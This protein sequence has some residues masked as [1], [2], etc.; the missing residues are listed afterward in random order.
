CIDDMWVPKNRAFRYTSCPE[1]S[2]G[3][4]AD[5]GILKG[6]AFAYGVSRDERL[7]EVLV[8]GVQFSM[9]DRETRA[10]R[11]VGKSISM[12]MRGAYQVLVDLPERSG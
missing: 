4:S 1:S 12:P 10:H 3:R 7:K 6:I 11:G 5:V 9:A 8:K 2:V